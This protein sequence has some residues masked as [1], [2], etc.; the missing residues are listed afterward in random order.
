MT[1]VKICGL[2]RVQDVEAALNH[3]ADAIGF[4]MEPTS[5]RYVGANMEIMDCIRSLGPYISTFAVYGHIA[6]PYPAVS[7]LQFVDGDTELP[8]VR[9]IRMRD[10]Q[11]VAHEHCDHCRA[12]LLDAFDPKAYGGTGKTLDWIAARSFVLSSPLPVILA[13]GLTPENVHSAISTVQPYG[14]DVS[15][16]VELSPGIKDPIKV[17]DFIQ[18]AHS[19]EIS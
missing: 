6:A 9:T 14:V 11:I 12:F 3:G 1:R 19:V 5:P 2:T 10:D 7:M 8:H 15:S 16:G 13:G 17:R 18:A 4:V